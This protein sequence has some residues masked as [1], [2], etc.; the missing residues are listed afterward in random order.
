MKIELPHTIENC[1]GEK[2]TFQSIEKT[3]NGDRINIEGFCQPGCGPTMHTHF[4]QD[5]ELTVVAGKMGYQT[6]GHEPHHLDE[7]KT[8]LFS[9][10]TPHK[11]W[12]EG[13]EPL[14]LEGWIAPANT[15]VFYLSALYAAQKK[16]GKAQPETFDAAY[17]MTRYAKEYDVPEIPIFVKRTIIP[18]TYF[19]GRL[20]GKYNHFKNAP[21][22]LK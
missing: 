6:L 21:L 14:H 17:L 20:L 12:A 15:I 8:I 3:Q 22:P 7:G 1:V 9:R 11:F 18:T 19:V 5:E 4:K 16:S 10:G 13:N 2:L